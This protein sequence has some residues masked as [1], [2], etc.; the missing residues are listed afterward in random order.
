MQPHGK[1]CLVWS[2]D[3]TLQQQPT[4][5][6]KPTTAT[7]IETHFTMTDSLCYNTHLRSLIE[8]KTA[9]NAKAWIIDFAIGDLVQYF[10]SK[11]LTSHASIHKL[12]PQWSPPHLITEKYINS[13]ELTDIPLPG[14]YH[15]H[16]LRPY[17]PLWNSTLDLIYPQ[18]TGLPTTDEIA[19]AG[20]EEQMEN[21]LKYPEASQTELSKSRTDWPQDV[22]HV[23]RSLCGWASLHKP[24]RA[25]STC[26]QERSRRADGTGMPPVVHHQEGGGTCGCAVHVT[27][28]P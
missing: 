10:N 9:F 11:H 7:D 15:T 25:L 12:K 4:P 13:S 8:P 1:S 21:D 16:Q 17:I 2:S 28:L 6:A 18:D 3:L 20:A 23:G 19:I 26:F 22:W 5:I 24:L 27:G 14:L